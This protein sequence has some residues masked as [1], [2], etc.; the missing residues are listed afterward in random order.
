MPRRPLNS[1]V[2]APMFPWLLLVLT[3][4]FAYLTYDAASLVAPALPYS[5]IAK[6]MGHDL[7]YMQLS[8]QEK[9]NRY[10]YLHR[11]GNLNQTVWLFAILT[12]GF[13]AATVFCISRMRH[14]T[15]ELT[16]IASFTGLLHGSR[17]KVLPRTPVPTSNQCS[18]P[19][20]NLAPFGRWT[21]RDKA[22]A[23]PVSS[24]LGLYKHARTFTF[25]LFC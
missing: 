24:T 22:R 1:D 7:S 18:N 5:E 2:R 17:I 8:D 13:A 11:L 25:Y 14:C 21:L 4:V 20:L 3:A 10:P 19:A 12:V 9:L 15:W 6:G 16:S 23:A